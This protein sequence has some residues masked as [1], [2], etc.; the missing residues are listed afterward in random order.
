MTMEAP[1]LTVMELL[2]VSSAF[3][4]RN[5]SG[6]DRDAVGVGGPQAACHG[7]RGDGDVAAAE[8][9]AESSGLVISDDDFREP[10]LIDER[11]GRGRNVHGDGR[12]G[13]VVG[14]AVRG[15]SCA[16]RCG[17]GSVRVHAAIGDVV[18]EQILG[19]G[20]RGR[21]CAGLGAPAV[22]ERQAAV[23]GERGDTQERY[24][25]NRDL[26]R[27]HAASTRNPVFP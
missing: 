1:P 14:K 5:L 6:Q 9:A 12:R 24:E 4:C 25:T 18:S 20:E 19:G 3:K 15:G 7:A 16:S 11:A 10:R 2:P 26:G 13:A 8:D 21:V 17:R 23:N 22:F 27:D